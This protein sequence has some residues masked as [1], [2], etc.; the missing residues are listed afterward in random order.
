[1]AS[2][3]NFDAMRCSELGIGGLGRR[4]TVYERLSSNM[5]AKW[6]CV[7][8]GQDWESESTASELI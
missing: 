6:T 2:P 5:L 7:G 8:Q 1:M 3:Q 4:W